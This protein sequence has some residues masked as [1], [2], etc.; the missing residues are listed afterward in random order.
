[1]HDPETQAGVP[2]VSELARRVRDFFERLQGEIRTALEQT[3]GK[4]AFSIDR[5]TRPGGGGGTASVIQEGAL[6]EKGG[7]NFSEV[8]GHLPERLVSAMKVATAQFYATGIS[9]VLHPRSPMVPT[10]HMN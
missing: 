6:F 2:E 1:M 9:L 10:V 3:D 5:W 8:Y 7:V 4:G